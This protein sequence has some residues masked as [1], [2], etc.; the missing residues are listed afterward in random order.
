[1]E[2]KWKKFLKP[3]WE[4]ILMFALLIGVIPLFFRLASHPNLE[5]WFNHLFLGWITSIGL[6]FN[7]ISYIRRIDCTQYNISCYS[8]SWDSCAFD[9]IVSYILSCLFIEVFNKVRKK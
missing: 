6:P 8:V 1:M 2:M 9:I 3:N 5:W 7:C 4:K